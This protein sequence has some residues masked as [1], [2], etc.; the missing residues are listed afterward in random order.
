MWKTLVDLV[1][2]WVLFPD[3]D[4]SKN[5][6]RENAHLYKT[7]TIIDRIRTPILEVTRQFRINQKSQVQILHR[8]F[9]QRAASAKTI[10]RCQ[11]DTLNAAVVDF[12]CFSQEH[13]H[14]VGLG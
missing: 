10:H 5:Q 11:G 7:K 4:I 3:A 13:M 14:Y 2:I 1:F 6:Y 9:P 8:Q 12:P